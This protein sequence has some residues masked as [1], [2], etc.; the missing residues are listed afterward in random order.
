VCEAALAA[1]GTAYTASDD[2]MAA[3]AQLDTALLAVNT[4]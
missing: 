3:F 4:R 2:R 1:L